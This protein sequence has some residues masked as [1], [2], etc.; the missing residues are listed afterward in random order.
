MHLKERYK[1]ISKSLK[2]SQFYIRYQIGMICLPEFDEAQ[3]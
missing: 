1:N 3:Y 2:I